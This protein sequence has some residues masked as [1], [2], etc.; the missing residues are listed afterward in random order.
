MKLFYM[1][2]STVYVLMAQDGFPDQNID[3]FIKK[4]I[5]KKTSEPKVRSKQKRPKVIPVLSPKRKRIRI[6]VVGIGVAPSFAHSKA[7]KFVL[8]KRAGMVDAYRLLGERLSGIRV[9]GRDTIRNM[10]VQKS[11]IKTYVED[12]IRNAVL[13]E[14][15]YKDG[16]CEV[17]LEV[18]VKYE[19]LI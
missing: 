15:I 16:M 2:I 8:C 7:Q 13:I 6:S 17:E 10:V 3:D 1:F 4:E 11:E 14:T 19:D 5:S 18:Q 12:T 9:E